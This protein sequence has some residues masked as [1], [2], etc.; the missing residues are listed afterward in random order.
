[1][2][3]YHSLKQFVKIIE[4]RIP[5]HVKV[6]AQIRLMWPDIVGEKMALRSQP[7]KCE[8]IPKKNELGQNTGQFY[9]RLVIFVSDSPTK[10]VITEMAAEFLENIPKKFHIHSLNV[11]LLTQKKLDIIPPKQKIVKPELLITENEKNNIKIRLNKINLNKD[12]Y[13]ALF[14]FL[15]ICKS[16]HNKENV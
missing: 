9:R 11:K 13:D 10:M 3:N 1:M 14:D 5:A 16:Q 4:S 15:C 2:Q 8:Y 7:A 6:V 12:V